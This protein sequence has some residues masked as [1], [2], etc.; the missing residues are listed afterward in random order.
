MT[1]E[2]E[3]EIV[4]TDAAEEKKREPLKS[5]NSLS[6][7]APSSKMPSALFSKDG[8]GITITRGSDGELENP[9]PSALTIHTCLNFS[10]NISQESDHGNSLG[11]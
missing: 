1:L 10:P 4:R 3:L 8:P 7:C 11:R 6:E 5:S 2:E 9:L